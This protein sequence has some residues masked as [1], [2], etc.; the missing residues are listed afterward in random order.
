MS[1]VRSSDII[2]SSFVMTIEF[3]TGSSAY[4]ISD[5]AAENAI[6]AAIVMARILFVFIVSPPYRKFIMY[7]L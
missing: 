1:V 2:V 7:K 6:A 4:A 3:V 5:D